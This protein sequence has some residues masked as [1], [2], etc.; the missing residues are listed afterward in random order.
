LH[1]LNCET[2]AIVIL[3]KS[4]MVV[5]TGA[6]QHSTKLPPH[7]E[8]LGSPGDGYRAR[9][10]R[11]NCLYCHRRPSLMSADTGRLVRRVEFDLE[12]HPI[13]ALIEIPQMEQPTEPVGAED[14]D[15]S[16]AHRGRR[17]EDRPA[18]RA[19]LAM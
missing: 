4:A 17:N 19:T 14:L 8:S 18:F 11:A 15:V 7:R 12:R 5:E 2:T 9:E 6:R 3:L 1:R 13:W 10:P 16:V